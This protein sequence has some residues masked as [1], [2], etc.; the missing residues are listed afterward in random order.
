MATTA[1]PGTL[2]IRPVHEWDEAAQVWPR[3]ARTQA[4]RGA[5]G[6]F[7]ERFAR[8]DNRVLGVRTIDLASAA[9]P[10]QFAFGGAARAINPYINIVNRLV[11]VQFEDFEGRVRTLAWEPTF[12]AGPAEAPYY[13]QL[14]RK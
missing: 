4:I 10:A 9:Y 13:G 3:G 5:A 12:T 6:A 8:P 7:R 14:L 1:A 2:E 11:L